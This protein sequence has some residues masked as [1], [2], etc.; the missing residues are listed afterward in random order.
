MVLGR[1]KYRLMEEEAEITRAIRR[2]AYHIRTA[3]VN[4][5]PFIGTYKRHKLTIIHVIILALIPIIFD[6][7]L[8]PMV[9]AAL[10]LAGLNAYGHYRKSRA[11]IEGAI[12]AGFYEYLLLIGNL[13]GYFLIVGLVLHFIT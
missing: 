8:I 12:V 5:N 11:T 3:Y 4:R 1:I 6:H 7:P 2:G 9:A 13:Y 10:I